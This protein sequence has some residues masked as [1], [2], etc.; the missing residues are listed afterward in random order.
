[1]PKQ[2]ESTTE[3]AETTSARSAHS[4]STQT[5]FSEVPKVATTNGSDDSMTTST[6]VSQKAN[7]TSSNVATTSEGHRNTAKSTQVDRKAGSDVST[8]K[9]HD[10][11]VGTTQVALKDEP[12]TTA[13]YYVSPISRRKLVFTSRK[14]ADSEMGNPVDVNRVTHAVSHVTE[15]ARV[16]PLI[17]QLDETRYVLYAIA[18]KSKQYHIF[19]KRLCF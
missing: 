10:D 5:T 9:G 19:C 3:V 18:G 15:P 2:N 1:M 12:S 6:Q 11:T 16:G 7:S 4:T 14:P 8:N 13:K 17:T